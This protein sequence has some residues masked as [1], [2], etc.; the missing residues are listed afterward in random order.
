M[1]VIELLIFIS[2][3]NFVCDGRSLECGLWTCVCNVCDGG[4]L[5][6]GLWTCVCEN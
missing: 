2:H 1:V 3:L 4:S 5:E 6:C